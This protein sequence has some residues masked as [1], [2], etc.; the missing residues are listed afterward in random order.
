[1]LSN[2]FKLFRKALDLDATEL[3]KEI[4]IK[5]STIYSYESGN[6]KPSLDTLK[7]LSEK[8]LLNL[9]W[10]ITGQG[11]MFNTPKNTLRA[12]YKLKK[13]KLVTFG[14]RLNKLRIHADMLTR[15]ISLL[16]EIKE[17]RFSDLC[18]G[19]VKPTLDEVICICENFDVTADW[20]L[21]E[22]E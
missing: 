21:F 11:D 7:L 18:I 20:L 17:D 16:L 3:A 5:T 6:S 12:K 13:D 1:M 22:K 14:K 10:Y 4:N 2:R 8:Y 15:E 19:A 9:Q